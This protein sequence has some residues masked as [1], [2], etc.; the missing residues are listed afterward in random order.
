M[1]GIYQ[2]IKTILSLLITFIILALKSL[3]Y[4][5]KELETKLKKER[6]IQKKTD[7]SL[8]KLPHPHKVITIILCTNTDK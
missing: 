5:L 3:P 6:Q 8:E 7:P 2:K 4:R 1:S